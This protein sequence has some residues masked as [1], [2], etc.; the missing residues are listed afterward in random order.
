MDGTYNLFIKNRRLEYNF[1]LNSK[2]TIIR[3][4]SASGKTTLHN[5]ISNYLIDSESSN[6]DISITPRCDIIAYNSIFWDC[7]VK[8]DNSIVFIDEHFRYLSDPEF[9]RF[10]NTSNNYFVITDRD[11]TVNIDYS[12]K[13]IYELHTSQKCVTTFRKY[14]NY[15]DIINDIAN[16]GA[17]I[18]INKIDTIITEDSKLGCDFY[19]HLY[20]KNTIS[21][22]NNTQIEN[23]I[24]ENIDDDLLVVVD[25]SAF[26]K[27]MQSVDILV[28][29]NENIHLFAPESFEYLL[30]KSNILKRA[31]LDEAM[32]Y[33][34]VHIDNILE[35][36][37]NYIDITRYTREQYYTEILNKCMAKTRHPYSKST[38][39]AFYF[40]TKLLSDARKII[41][42]KVDNFLE[43]PV[44]LSEDEVKKMSLE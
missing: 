11:D 15:F 18:S 33:N 10:L 28:N 37:E 22:Y 38:K 43:N 30:L 3:G 44:K 2:F 36:P 14:S 17:S 19:K 41:P 16:P 26:G 32:Y 20:G 5:I 27:F 31:N 40:S 25:G 23:K 29:E 13:D 34:N 4:D 42:I 9:N 12:I 21:A 1:N 35:A 7:G 6:I 39:D 8:P 24:K